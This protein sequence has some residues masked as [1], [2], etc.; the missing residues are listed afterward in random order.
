MSTTKSKQMCSGCRDDFYNQDRDGGCWSFEK[1]KVRLGVQVGTWEPPPYDKS[2]AR[3]FLSCFNP[4][5]YSTLA[6]N[7]VRIKEI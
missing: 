2:R 4:I 3:E 6:M 7:D 5:G 1:A